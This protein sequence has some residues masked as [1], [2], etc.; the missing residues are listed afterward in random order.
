MTALSAPSA[1]HSRGRLAGAARTPI[2]VLDLETTGFT[3]LDRITE[4]SIISL[5]PHTLETVE[6][7]DTLVNPQRD[8][9]AEVSAVHG[10]TASILEA[11]PTFAEI[12]P[13]V[14][15]RLNGS[16]IVAHNAPF[17]CRFLSQEIEKANGS[18]DEGEPICTFQLTKLALAKACIEHDIQLEQAHRSLED[19][20]AT[21]V[22]LRELLE[23]GKVDIESEHSTARCR[24]S[25]NDVVIRTLRREATELGG[26][27]T[28]TIKSPWQDPLMDYR[29][30]VNVALDDNYI[31]IDER[32][33]LDQLAH[34][35]GLSEKE[36][37]EQ[38]EVLFKR[39]LEATGRDG[40]ISEAE[41]NYLMQLAEAL[42]IDYETQ[43][44]PQDHT[45]QLMSGMSVCFTGSGG[46][47]KP[48]EAMVQIAESRRL[49]VR[50]G[51]SQKLDM[52]IAADT[53]S[54]S[55]KTRKAREHGI[56]VISAFDFLSLVSD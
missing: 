10:L 8:I 19:A 55:T 21:V 36:V 1:Q 7:Y 11:A 26:N 24:F 42:D 2:V 46:A 38:H 29:Y 9:S 40:H 32:V 4:I 28:R 5:D 48:R 51:V 6:E 22:L 56:T 47:M 43:F 39:A 41:D 53:S 45:V 37:Q 44:T 34:I 33:E 54:F 13:A 49:V 31:S 50:S 35:L 16:Y 12:L 52:L 18:F 23:Q 30:A 20:R 25:S 27:T 14:A 3:P 17:D 15:K